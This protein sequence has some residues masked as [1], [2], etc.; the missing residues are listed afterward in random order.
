MNYISTLAIRHCSQLFKREKEI[1]GSRRIRKFRGPNNRNYSSISGELV[2]LQVYNFVHVK[3]HLSSIFPSFNVLVLIIMGYVATIIYFFII[4]LTNLSICPTWISIPE[5]IEF[6][7][8]INFYPPSCFFIFPNIPSQR[9]S[10]NLYI[11]REYLSQSRSIARSSNRGMWFRKICRIPI[12]RRDIITLWERGG[13]R[14]SRNRIIAT[15]S[16]SL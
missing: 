13:A 1:D 6:R 12:A 10:I 3:V 8:G 4:C 11:Y 5:Y 7:F 14:F 9:D 15:V 2:S 16:I